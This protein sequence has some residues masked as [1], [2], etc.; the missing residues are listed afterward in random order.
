MKKKSIIVICGVL[1][2]L[3][4]VAGV[5]LL[6]LIQK[7]EL[8]EENDC[9]W[10]NWTTEDSGEYGKKTSFKRICLECGE[11][12]EYKVEPCSHLTYKYDN[13]KN[14]IVTGAN[15]CD[16]EFLYI[17]SKAPDGT[18]VVNI[19]ATAFVGNTTYSFVYRFSFI[20]GLLV[21]KLFLLSK[22]LTINLNN[23][24][25]SVTSFSFK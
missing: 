13:D 18:S 8:P 12:Q 6:L 11:E 14:Y 3:I 25:S 24:L 2:I 23:S 5:V 19:G 1:A 16:C 21:N 9:V 20:L 10:S 22:F 7:D 17:L 4:A 15:E